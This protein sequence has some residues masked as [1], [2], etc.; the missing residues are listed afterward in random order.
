MPLKQPARVVPEVCYQYCTAQCFILHHML[1]SVLSVKTLSVGEYARVS[2][3]LGN[4]SSVITLHKCRGNTDIMHT[5]LMTFSEK[6][7]KMSVNEI[8]MWLFQHQIGRV[9]FKISYLSQPKQNQ[10]G[11]LDSLQI[12]L[13]KS[14]RHRQCTAMFNISAKQLI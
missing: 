7:N 14:Q 1:W 12:C 13:Q 11:N 2:L 4:A 10:K 6:W 3:W 5:I 8:K 9:I